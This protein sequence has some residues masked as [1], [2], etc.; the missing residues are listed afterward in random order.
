MRP[1]ERPNGPRNMTGLLNDVVDEARRLIAAATEQSVMLRVVGGVAVRLLIPDL[2]A[3]LQHEYKDID[4]VTSAGDTGNVE[5]FLAAAGYEA[6][7]DVNTLNGYR[8]LLFYDDPNRRRVDC[9]SAPSR[10]A[11]P[12]RWK[13][14]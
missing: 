7:T 3:V 2:P 8:R 11:T 14:A 1:V 4:I 5:S 13:G 9:S 12:F 10:C 6:D